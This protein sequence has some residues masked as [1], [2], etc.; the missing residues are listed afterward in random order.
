MPK[1]RGASP[2]C[3]SGSSAR[4][5][6]H[7]PCP[8]F[9]QESFAEAA[10]ASEYRHCCGEPGTAGHGASAGSSLCAQ[11][12]TSQRHLPQKAHLPGRPPDSPRAP[13]T[14]GAQFS[15]PHLPPPPHS[16]HRS[17]SPPV[18]RADGGT[19]GKW[20]VELSECMG[21]GDCTGPVHIGAQYWVPLLIG[22]GAERRS[23]F[24]H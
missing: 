24:L 12:A 4:M 11:G 9:N 13:P 7:L 10:A 8:S 14:A 22:S 23:W 17:H 18:P 1:L 3:A 21:E 16:E 20:P 15:F 6:G 2:P 5:T 19:L